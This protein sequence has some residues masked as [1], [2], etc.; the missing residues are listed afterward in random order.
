MPTHPCAYSGV[1]SVFCVHLSGAPVGWTHPLSFAPSR[2]R[3]SIW[4]QKWTAGCVI[5]RSQ[6]MTLAARMPESCSHWSSTALGAWS[7]PMGLLTLCRKGCKRAMH[8]V[9]SLSCESGSARSQNPILRALH[10]KL[11]SDRHL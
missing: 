10:G 3:T 5:H 2:R 7:C 11:P 6:S 8:M 1:F 4:A 9:K